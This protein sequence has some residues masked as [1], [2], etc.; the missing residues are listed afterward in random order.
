MKLFVNMKLIFLKVCKFQ[1][2]CSVYLE[3]NPELDGTE[4][5]Q[6]SYVLAVESGPSLPSR[7]SHHSM[8][9]LKYLPRY[10]TLPVVQFPSS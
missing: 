1:L 9:P 7:A 10:L 6:V 4:P 8:I 5:K 2:D 3:R